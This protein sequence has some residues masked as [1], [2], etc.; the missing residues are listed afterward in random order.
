M[1]ALVCDQ[2]EE[3]PA[4]AVLLDSCHFSQVIFTDVEKF[5]IPG[6]DVTCHYTLSEHI[7]PQKKDWVGIFRVGWKTT[8]E[9]YTFMWA[10]LPSDSNSNLQQL[11]FKAYYLP[12]DDE[13][14]QFCYI[15][16]DGQVRGASVPFQFRAEAEDDMLVVT[17]Q[18]EV[19]QIEQQNT[20]LL[21]EN[22][23]L[24]EKES[25]LQQQKEDL[26]ERIRTIEEEKW[27]LE[28]KVRL[29][30][31]ATVELERAQNLQALEKKAAQAEVVALTEENRKLQKE[32][33]EQKRKLEDKV[34][35]LQAANVELERAQNLQGLEK[36]AA[37]AE[38][39]ALTEENRK[40]QKEQED[41]QR[42]LDTLRSSYEKLSLEVNHFKNQIAG[43]EAQNSSTEKE[44]QQIKEEKRKLLIEQERLENNLKT[45]QSHVDQLQSQA[46]NQQ[47]EVQKLKGVNQENAKQLQQLKEENYQL[48]EALLSQQHL[49]EEL[50][51]KTHLLQTLQKEI[52]QKEKANQNLRRENEGLMACL[53]KMIDDE[54]VGLLTQ[55]A[56]NSGLLFGNPYSAPTEIPATDLDS[57]KR[58]PVCKKVFSTDVG[59]Q[60]FADHVGSHILECPFCP[61]T[62]DKS[63]KQVY[64]DH[65]YCHH[66]D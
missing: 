53:P 27:E 59:E 34:H 4:S 60:Q 19:E 38:I 41:L 37:L 30:Q 10:T 29:L 12:T 43:L 35:L 39:A 22:Q 57:V 18:G 54:P 55:S 33:E 1:E 65:I 6:A 24:K 5:Y 17:T 66:L 9:Y 25:A 23:K 50:E 48:N 63:N 56:Q 32:Q 51:E 15:D 2:L 13:Y 28:D 21:Q 31:A 46:Q 61:E 62:F 42:S 36:K 44:L 58:C 45:T 8:R 14:Y 26:Q 64:E 7:T 16:Q 49:E 3:P 40:L 20:A 47:K 11:L 52:N